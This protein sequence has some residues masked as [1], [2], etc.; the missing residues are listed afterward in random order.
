MFDQKTLVINCS[1]AIVNL[2]KVQ[3]TE[4]ENIVRRYTRINPYDVPFTEVHCDL[5]GGN[6]IS[7]DDYKAIAHKAKA[8]GEAFG[9]FV[10]FEEFPSKTIIT[11]WPPNVNDHPYHTLN[12]DQAI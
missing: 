6:M 5:G 3:A 11:V 4:R 12:V 1:I 10:Q 2:V 7:D 9:C 8:V